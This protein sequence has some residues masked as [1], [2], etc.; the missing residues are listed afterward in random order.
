[1]IRNYWLIGCPV[2]SLMDIGPTF[3]AFSPDSNALPVTDDDNRQRYRVDVLS[4]HT[5]NVYL[6]DRLELPKPRG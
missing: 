6:R 4:R 3:T 2:K 5:L 1:L